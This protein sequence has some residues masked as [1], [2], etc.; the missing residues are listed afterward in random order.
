MMRTSGKLVHMLYRAITY[1]VTPLI[2]CHIQWRRFRGLEHPHRW[3]ERFGYPSSSRLHGRPLLWFH[4]VSLGEG[5]ATLPILLHCAQCLPNITILM[6]TTTTS[7]FYV[8]KDRL[9]SSVIYQFAPIDAPVAVDTFLMHWNPIAVILMENELWPNLIM[10]ASERG[11]PLA[12]L[13]ARMS[14]KSFQLWSSPIASSLISLLL[15]KFSLILPTS[16]QQAIRFQLLG[17]PPFIVN[18]SGDLKYEVGHLDALEQIPEKT[19]DLQSQLSL[20][21]VWMAAST[22]EDEEQV[23][24]CVHKELMKLYPQLLTIIV[25]RY[26]EQGRHIAQAVLKEGMTAKLRSQSAN[27]CSSTNFY[28]VDTLGELRDL[29]RLTPIAVIGGSFLRGLCGH[30]VSEAAAAGCAVLTGPYIGHFSEMV[31]K[32]KQASHLSIQQVS[33]IDELIKALSELLDD[34]KILD[35]RQV[36]ARQ[37]YL[38]LSG[39]VVRSVWNLV[40]AHVLKHASQKCNHNG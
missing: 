23:M 1:A 36:A 7:A 37:A 22:H 20:R 33:G 17:A 29:Y 26:P 40:D 10:A 6:T 21:K 8:I 24:F 35:A 39:R 11:I 19:R 13:N 2:Y 31:R 30:N 28:I 4:A 34:P 12:L 38:A 16:T 9:P 3:P 27:I 18:F 32:M 5:M 14:E 15:S 25:P